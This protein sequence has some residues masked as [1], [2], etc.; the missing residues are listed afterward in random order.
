MR[1]KDKFLPPFGHLLVKA[2]GAKSQ[3]QVALEL[4]INQGT[5]SRIETGECIP[6]AKNAITLA[7]WLN[8]PLE[9]VLKMAIEGRRLFKE[10]KKAT[11]PSVSVQ[12]VEQRHAESPLSTEAP[13]SLP[14]AAVGN[15]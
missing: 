11:A 4:N 8:M 13:F 3:D 6:T 1:K 12:K 10:R 15:P 5:F 14:S 2:R 7:Q 9:E